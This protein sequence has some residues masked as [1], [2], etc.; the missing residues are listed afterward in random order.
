MA[1]E[2]QITARFHEVD[3]AGIVFFN[4]VYEYAH[5][6]FEEMLW[7]AFGPPSEVYDTADVGFPLV[8]SEADYRRPIQ[9][10]DRLTIKLEVEKMSDRS[11]TFR[12][13]FEGQDGLPR[14][15]VR[16]KHAFVSLKNFQPVPRT[17]EFTR[18]L[19]KVGLIP[20]GQDG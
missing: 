6:C 18:G 4:R 3:R 1:F 5:I 8:H 17:A 20:A 7:E 15:T 19:E 13:E 11:V 12:Y 14:A 10:G 2:H 16:L 9:H